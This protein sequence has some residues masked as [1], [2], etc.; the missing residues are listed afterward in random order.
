MKN[1]HLRLFIVQR[2]RNENKKNGKSECYLLKTEI[3]KILNNVNNF[4]EIYSS[5]HL[6]TRKKITKV[7]SWILFFNFCRWK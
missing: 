5:Y 6:Q 7:M 1:P 3:I 4:L 2:K